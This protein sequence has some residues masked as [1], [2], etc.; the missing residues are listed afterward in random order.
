MTEV[1]RLLRGWSGYFHFRHSS[2]VLGKL[3]WWVETRLQRWLWRKHGRRRLLWS[4][5]PVPL[6]DS[7]YGLWP[8]PLQAGRT[9]QTPS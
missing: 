9:A 3:R 6:L 2:R 5:Y 4:G 1:N 7:R 8:M